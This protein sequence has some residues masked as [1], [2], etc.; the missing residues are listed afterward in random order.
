LTT[1]AGLTDDELT[2]T[3]VAVHYG[4]DRV[5]ELI[6]T[7]RACAVLAVRIHVAAEGR[8]AGWQGARQPVAPWLAATGPV[9][10]LVSSRVVR[11]AFEH[12]ATDHVRATGVHDDRTQRAEEFLV[13]GCIRSADLRLMPADEP[14]TRWHARDLRSHLGRGGALRHL[15]DVA[16]A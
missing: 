5:Q 13:S 6:G 7:V 15:H 16:L 2:P 1:G 12:R 10:V 8:D 3:V 14:G 4:N 11:R 9:V